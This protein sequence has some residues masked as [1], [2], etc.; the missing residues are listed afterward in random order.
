MVVFGRVVISGI[1]NRTN[2]CLALTSAQ[3]RSA[4]SYHLEEMFLIIDTQEE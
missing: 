3:D 2:F 1:K 4:E